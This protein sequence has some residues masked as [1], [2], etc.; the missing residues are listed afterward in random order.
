MMTAN[1]DITNYGKQGI[2]LLK[3]TTENNSELGDSSL[4][5]LKLERNQILFL[6]CYNEAFT[7]HL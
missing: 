6:P 3:H 5:M 1:A 4:N 7:I 2:T